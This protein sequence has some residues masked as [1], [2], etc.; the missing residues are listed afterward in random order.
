LGGE[1]PG[2]FSQNVKD[3]LEVIRDFEVVRGDDLLVE[4]G[5]MGRTFEGVFDT[6]VALIIETKI[7]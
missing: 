2:G 3:S 1:V 4:D 6:A 7:Q 5:S